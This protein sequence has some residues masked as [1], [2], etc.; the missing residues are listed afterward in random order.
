MQNVNVAMRERD[1]SS[2]FST[3]GKFCPDYGLLLELHALILVARSHAVLYMSTCLKAR[4]IVYMNKYKCFDK[5]QA[6]LCTFMRKDICLTSSYTIFLGNYLAILVKLVQ[7]S[8]E[9][10]MYCVH[11]M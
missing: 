10:F 11:N 1:Q 6:N 9:C 8:S 4:Y 7:V 5:L 3:S 2:I